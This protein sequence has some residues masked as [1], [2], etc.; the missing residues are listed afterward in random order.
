MTEPI[1]FDHEGT[2]IEPAMSN[3]LPVGPGS[4]GGTYD[5][6]RPKYHRT[7]RQNNPAYRTREILRSRM[8]REAARDAR[9]TDM[10]SFTEAALVLV[11]LEVLQSSAHAV[12]VRIGIDRNSARKWLTGLR[13]PAFQID[14]LVG[15]YGVYAIANGMRMSRAS[16]NEI[17]ENAAE[18]LP[19]RHP[20]RH[21][22]R[23]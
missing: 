19:P 5:A 7:W 4:R 22:V 16:Y 23:S 9:A 8:R 11:A 10:I 1:E 3:R 20:R 15:Y 18:H 21:R 13:E 6:D 17:I 14:A 2:L 12:S